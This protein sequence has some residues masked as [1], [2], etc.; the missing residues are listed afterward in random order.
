MTI[1]KAIKA[2]SGQYQQ[3]K[4]KPLDLDDLRVALDQTAND[5]LHGS[6]CSL[7]GGLG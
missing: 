7:T 4:I 3:Q 5:A 6:F 1:T 2:V